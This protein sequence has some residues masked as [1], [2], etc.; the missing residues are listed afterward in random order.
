MKEPEIIL[1][2][3]ESEDEAYQDYQFNSER[4]A[5]S[6][7]KNCDE[8]IKQKKSSQASDDNSKLTISVLVSQNIVVASCKWDWS[9]K[10]ANKILSSLS[11]IKLTIKSVR[12]SEHKRAFSKWSYN[13]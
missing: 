11:A 5:F 13:N 4:R 9:L 3:S 8:L 1:S 6:L 10:Q 12:Q 7:L 2:Q